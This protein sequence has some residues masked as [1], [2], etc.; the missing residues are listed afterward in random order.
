MGENK[1]RAVR[2]NRLTDDEVRL[3]RAN[4][5]FMWRTLGTTPYAV[6]SS[7]NTAYRVKNNLLKTMGWFR[8][9]RFVLLVIGEITFPPPI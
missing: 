4:Y 2:K 5:K 3:F 7:K 1:K 6:Q 8:P 9:T